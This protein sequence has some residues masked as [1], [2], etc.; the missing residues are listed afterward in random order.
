[1]KKLL[2]L[3]MLTISLMSFS[4]NNN[5]LVIND[6]LNPIISVSVFNQSGTRLEY[7]QNISTYDDVSFDFFLRNA[8]GYYYILVERENGTIVKRI[9]I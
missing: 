8:R 9:L 2:V 7:Y 3:V 5:N 1:M 4:Q 6:T